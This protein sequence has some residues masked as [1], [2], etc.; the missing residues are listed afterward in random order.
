MNT[1]YP[2]KR[3]SSSFAGLQKSKPK[4]PVGILKQ[5]GSDDDIHNGGA[6]EGPQRQQQAEQFSAA[7]IRR[8]HLSD[9]DSEYRE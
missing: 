3:K 2:S 7:K 8:L 1:K 6:P 9:P 5:L 4:D